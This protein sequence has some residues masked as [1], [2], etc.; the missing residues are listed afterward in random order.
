MKTFILYFLIIFFFKEQTNIIISVVLLYADDV[1]LL[2]TRWMMMLLSRC[3][4]ASSLYIYI[5]FFLIIKMGCQEWSFF[6]HGDDDHV[7]LFSLF[8]SLEPGADLDFEWEKTIEYDY[9]L[10][11]FTFTSK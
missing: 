4:P 7:L 8:F 2:V 3:L 9:Q 11:Y 5:Y 6:Q 10:I 1:S